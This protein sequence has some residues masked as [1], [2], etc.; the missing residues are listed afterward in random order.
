M[1][2]VSIVLFFSIAISDMCK[3][4]NELIRKQQRPVQSHYGILEAYMLQLILIIFC[5]LKA[6]LIDRLHR[7]SSSMKTSNGNLVQDISYRN[8]EMKEFP[9]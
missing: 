4:A 6:I 5:W 2:V 3:K 1:F 9:L 7:K 8:I